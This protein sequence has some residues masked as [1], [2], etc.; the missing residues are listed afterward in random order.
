M[1]EDLEIV[2]VERMLFN[3]VCWII[4]GWMFRWFSM[5][6]YNEMCFYEYLIV[7]Y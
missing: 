7:K 3:R 4:V 5:V 1:W 6:V 2:L